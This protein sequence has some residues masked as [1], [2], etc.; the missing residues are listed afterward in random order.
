MSQSLQLIFNILVGICGFFGGW[1]LKLIW[2]AIKDLKQKENTV[3]E[4]IN[5]IQVKIA[6]EYVKKDYFEKKVDAMFV[7]LDNIFEKL[8]KKADR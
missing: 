7:K 1:M 6:E 5:N 3:S 2:D 8:D 4:Q